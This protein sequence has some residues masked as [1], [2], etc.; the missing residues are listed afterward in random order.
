MGVYFPAQVFDVRQHHIGRLALELGVLPATDA[1]YVGCET[2][3]DDDIFNSGVASDGNA[4]D[5]FEAMAE[6]DFTRDV[7]E[8]GVKFGP[9]EGLLRDLSEGNTKTCPQWLILEPFFRLSVGSAAYL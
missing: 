6:V 4:A 8:R 5:D 2:S 9:G 3:I 7:T 1:G